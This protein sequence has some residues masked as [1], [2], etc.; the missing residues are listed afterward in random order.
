MCLALTGRVI[1]TDDGDAIV[2][3]RGRTVRGSCLLEPATRAGDWVSV[4][5]GWVVARLTPDEAAARIDL[6]RQ[7]D[8]P[9][10]S[11]DAGLIER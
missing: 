11:A 8:G 2:D 6:E 9:D 1:T 7:L 10:R 4:S 5:A 3:V